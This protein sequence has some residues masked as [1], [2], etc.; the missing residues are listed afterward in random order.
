G[1]F[2]SELA[3]VVRTGF[4]LR[5]SAPRHGMSPSAR[6]FGPGDFLREVRFA[7]RGFVQGP[8]H[9]LAAVLTLGIGVAIATAAFSAFNAL[10]LRPLPHR[11]P[12]QL[13]QLWRTLPSI[14]MPRGPTS[15]PTFLDWKQGLTLL[16][17]AAVYTNTVATLTG[18]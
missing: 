1:V 5:Q 7:V 6:R 2:L 3:D 15:Y 17:D 10:L 14:A 9:A 18:G 8:R 4:R 12:E 11:A 13:V 16:E